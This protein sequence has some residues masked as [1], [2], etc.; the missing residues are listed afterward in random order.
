MPWTRLVHIGDIELTLALAAAISAW[1]VTA[2]ASRMA[3]WWTLLFTVGI[4]L[5][6]AS[7]VAFMAWGMTLHSL[8]F[9]AVS[10]HSTGV[11]AVFPT[12]FYLLLRRRGARAQAAGVAAGLALGALMAVLLVAENEH[13]AAEALAGWV[14]GAAISLGA[15]RMAGALPPSRA[16]PH[17]LLYSMLVFASAAWVMHAVPH[18]YLMFRTA[19]LISGQL[20][21]FPWSAGS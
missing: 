17:D 5:V 18:G 11:T 16:R 10:G 13:S 21:S 12:L 8:D 6:G 3:L 19:A 7:K 15:I 4:G 2:R 14:T 1:L 20:T 9:K